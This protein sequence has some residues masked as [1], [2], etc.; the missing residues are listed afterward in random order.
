MVTDVHSDVLAH[1]LAVLPRPGP[2]IWAVRVEYT[3]RQPAPAQWIAVGTLRLTAGWP[4]GSDARMVTGIGRT[5][6][7]AFRD[8]AKRV[9][10]MTGLPVN[11]LRG[12]MIWEGHEESDVC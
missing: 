5:L 1:L 12:V 11:L 2:P 8:L 9:S 7:D 6:D 4:T 10:T 3:T